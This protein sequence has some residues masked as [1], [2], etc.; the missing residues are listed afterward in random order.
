MSS[1]Q[2]SIVIFGASGDL[3]RRK[4]VPALYNLYK[5]NRLPAGFRIVGYARS[6]LDDD[7]FRERLRSG[8][9]EFDQLAEESWA[10][11]AS[12]L[13]YVQGSYDET[14]ACTTLNARLAE[15]EPA[16]AGRLYYLSTPPRLY[17]PIVHCLG[18]AGMVSPEKGWRRV[19]IEK[20]FGHDLASAQSL[21]Q[22][23]HQVLAEDQI[24]RIDHYLGKETVQNMLVFRFANTIFEPIWNRNFI[25]NV[26]I[27]A[28]EA[29]DVGHRAGYYDGVGV[30]RDMFQNHLMQL[31]TLVS[32]E[33]P[34]SFAANALR[35]E[36]VK[37]LSAIRPFRPEDIATHTVRGQYDGYCRADGVAPDSDTATF[38]ALKLNIDNWRWQGV[39]FYLR[40]GKALAKKTTEVVIRFKRPP[41]MMFPMEPGERLRSNYLAICVQPDEG[42]HLRFEAK[43]PDTAATMRPVDMEFHYADAF[44]GADIP[45]AYERLLLDAINGDASLFT[46]ADEIELS[47]RLMDSILDGWRTDQAPK[48]AAY[49]PG[50][51]GPAEADDLLGR[52]HHHWTSGCEHD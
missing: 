2:A 7:S 29:V 8:V 28:A 24:Y 33:P 52:D 6:G 35:N 26:Q 41:H 21:N 36:K 15:L 51:W 14:G 50:S 37:V 25:S 48:L 27:T 45:D 31:L 17:A 22:D 34:T 11:F 23:I 5:K 9:A 4:L 30:V 18:Q 16:G 46:R 1:E 13:F 43:Q 44:D 40:S 20:P 47:W 32:M 19:I 42:I 10:K 39:P 38:A 12:C 49:E 3:T